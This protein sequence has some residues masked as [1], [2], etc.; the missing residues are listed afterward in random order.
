MKRIIRLKGKFYKLR[1]LRENTGKFFLKK[2]TV[3]LYLRKNRKKRKYMVE[4]KIDKQL[5]KL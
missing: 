3:M 2:K 1:K 5:K 4:Q